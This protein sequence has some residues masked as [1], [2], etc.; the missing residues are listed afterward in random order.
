MKRGSQP[1]HAGATTPASALSIGT[2]LA[3]PLT[4]GTIF[5]GG[6]A[7]ELALDVEV[8]REFFFTIAASLSSSVRDRFALFSFSNVA[9][10]VRVLLVPVR[11]SST[12]ALPLSLEGTLRSI[13]LCLVFFA[14]SGCSS[15]SSSSETPSSVGRLLMAPKVM[16]SPGVGEMSGLSFSSLT[17][18]ID[19]IPT[20]SGLSGE[21]ASIRIRLRGLGFT[22]EYACIM[23]VAN[24]FAIGNGRREEGVLGATG[25][26]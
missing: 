21:F 20:F 4:F 15:S 2:R 16:G 19:G 17:V 13:L 24:G 3:P 9:V 14:R 6:T 18:P 25:P 10:V 1:F 8:D 11:R 23:R 26:S 5:G 12:R 22:G 7:A